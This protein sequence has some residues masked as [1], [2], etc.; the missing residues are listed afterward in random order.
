MKIWTIRAPVRASMIAT[1]LCGVTAHAQT[2]TSTTVGVDAT[3]TLKDA[4]PTPLSLK[5]VTP[6]SFGTLAIPNNP[7]R[8]DTRCRYNLRARA[9][10][11][12]ATETSFSE[13]DG[14][15]TVA[16]APSG[17]GFEGAQTVGQVSVTCQTGLSVFYKVAYNLSASSAMSFSPGSTTVAGAIAKKM[18]FSESVP[19]GANGSF[20]CDPAADNKMFLL[21]N[22]TLDVRNSSSLTRGSKLSVGTV[23][24]DVNY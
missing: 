17:C 12:S 11:V 4:P 9:N 19:L 20:S 15:A 2:S 24:I 1:T 18:P 10:D 8:P 21:L 22:A 3:A 6:I 23:T 14:G 5:T 16:G 7:A 13:V